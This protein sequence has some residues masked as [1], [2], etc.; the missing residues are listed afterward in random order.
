MKKLLLMTFSLL[1]IT[2]SV[3]TI[4][5][6]DK[7]F[8]GNFEEHFEGTM[9]QKSQ[10]VFT[11]QE[12]ARKNLQLAEEELLS[13]EEGKKYN[14]AEIAYNEC[15]KACEKGS[16]SFYCEYFDLARKT[17][18]VKL[19]QRPEYAENYLPALDKHTYH[20]Y[21]AESI[22][23][24]NQTLLRYNKSKFYIYD[25]TAKR[26]VVRSHLF[27]S[28]REAIFTGI[29]SINPKS[30]HD[31]SKSLLAKSNDYLAVQEKAKSSLQDYFDRNF[32]SP[33][34]QA[35]AI[36]S[37]Q[38]MYH[39]GKQIDVKASE[40]E[41]RLRVFPYI[42]PAIMACGYDDNMYFKKS[43][44]VNLTKHY[45]WY[46]PLYGNSS[47]KDSLLG[48]ITTP[49]AFVAA[50]IGIEKAAHELNQ[51]EAVNNITKS[52]PK[53][54]RNFLYQN[55]K[56]ILASAFS[57]LARTAVEDGGEGMTSTNAMKFGKKAAIQAG[58]DF[59]E[60]YGVEPSSHRLF[61]KEDS[62]QKAAFN[63][64]T[65]GA[66]VL[67]LSYLFDETASIDIDFTPSVNPEDPVLDSN[68]KELLNIFIQSQNNE[69]KKAIAKY[70][71][72]KV[73]E[74]NLKLY[75]HQL[76]PKQIEKALSI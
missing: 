74:H 38:H 68:D 59:V 72:C 4:T 21:K 56:L 22:K 16:E 7:G 32:A 2:N 19:Q 15:A 29:D 18:L 54:S 62:K 10:K 70:L 52:I 57:E 20:S 13:T 69:H 46:R 67:G 66:I 28:N 42:L 37:L 71:E 64:F 27:D 76:T 48:P 23:S 43:K 11:N 34:S 26:Y 61:G 3:I 14:S 65:N 12:K 5:A 8:L 63:F 47:K 36:K 24:I 50:D 39:V 41:I 75:Q 58:T 53:Y 35:D 25:H 73:A 45:L 30:S 40:L 60:K 33:F 9:K 49:V 6:I 17:A 51:F 44:A 31:L 55:G 1:F